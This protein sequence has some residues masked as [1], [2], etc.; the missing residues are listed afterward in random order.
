MKILLVAAPAVLSSKTSTRPTLHTHLPYSLLTY[1]LFSSPD[2][3]V[4]YLV[5]FP[6]VTG[7]ALGIL[8]L[9]TFLGFRLFSQEFLCIK[10]K[11][12]HYSF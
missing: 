12:I 7:I 5:P 4:L 2:T 6:L 11:C 1:P 3:L 10:V 9:P 8:S